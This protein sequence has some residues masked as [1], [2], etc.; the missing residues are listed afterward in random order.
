MSD[1]TGTHGTGRDSGRNGGP[2]SGPG[3]G[4][5]EALR[6]WRD[7]TDPA[8]VGLPTGRR[9]RAVGLRRE[10]LALLAG[11]SV[12]YVTR[13]EQGRAVS[14]SAQVLAALARALRLSGPESRHLF[15]LAGQAPPAHGRM[16]TR[17]TPGVRRLLDRLAD[18]P[19]GVYDAS[20]TLIAWNRPH[21]ALLGDPSELTDRER[22]VPWCHFAG[23]PG[24][25][26]H[27]PEQEARFEAAVVADL[28][29]A[30]ARYPSEARLWSLVDDLRNTGD[31]FARLWDSH[32]VGVHE[33]D[34]KTVHH[35]SVGPLVLD[36]D[37]LTVPDG[38]LR[39]VVHTAAPGTESA[40]RLGLLTAAR[41]GA[42]R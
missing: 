4:L 38:D 14:P 20:W 24:R 7:R 40:D 28:R 18:T 33:R 22:N 11:V 9:R 10:E 39:V 12:D 35:P 31:R 30:T 36:C 27:T 23:P 5:G 3:S 17:P 41:P 1:G 13:L 2:G 21:T 25:V 29:A 8:S 42:R 15:L 34:T 19:V 32:V 26:R 16:A 37:V 6:R